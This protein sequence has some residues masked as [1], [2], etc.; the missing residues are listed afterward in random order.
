MHSY[1]YI[2][3]MMLKHVQIHAAIV[4]GQSQSQKE[5][6]RDFYVSTNGG[7]WTTSTNWMTNVHECQWY[8]VTCDNNDVVVKLDLSKY[9]FVTFSLTSNNKLND[10][11]SWK[12]NH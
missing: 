6:L 7:G 12:V 2:L 11:F 8:G 4:D 9:S 5:I 1:W 10:H 3:L